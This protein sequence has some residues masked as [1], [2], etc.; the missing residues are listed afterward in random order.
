MKCQAET[1]SF[2]FTKAELKALLAFASEDGTRPHLS[3]VFFEPEKGSAVTMDGHVLAR[4]KNSGTFKGRPFLVHRDDLE[5]LAKATAARDTC[6]VTFEG[7]HPRVRAG[8]LGVKL[9]V[10]P[11]GRE[12]VP[13]SET[14]VTPV[15]AAFPPYEQTI[16]VYGDRKPVARVGLNA[17]YLA[18]LA[19]I[20]KICSDSCGVICELGES[21]LDPALFTARDAKAGCEWTMVIMPMRV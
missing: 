9:T 14:M 11:L 1:K 12:D 6:S 2:V 20:A 21:A 15:D 5:R 7:R 10:H 8:E 13:G 4:V 18:Q 19:P 16:P 3:S 17:S